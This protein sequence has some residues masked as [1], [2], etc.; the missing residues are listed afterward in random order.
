ML[1]QPVLGLVASAL[2]ILISL[3]FVALFP[4]A[5]F[6]GSVTY[7][8][9][10]IVPMEIVVG[11]TWGC[12]QP[13]FAAKR[14]QPAKGAFL[15]LLTGII[16]AIV[17][18]AYF[19]GVGGGVRPISPMLMMCT[20]VSVVVTF[21]AAIIWGGWPFT[22]VIKN[23]VAA[24][25][26]MLAACYI[27]NYVLFRLFF[28]YEFMRGAA[29][30]TASLDP[31]GLFNANL[32]LVFYLTALAVMFLM[33]HLDLWP[34]TNFPGL[35]KQ[36]VLGLV[37]TAICLALG[38][39]IFYIG[40]FVLVMD[41][42]QFM[43][44]VPIPFIFGTIIVLNMLQGSLFAKYAQPLKG[45]LSA[46]AAAVIGTALAL[47]YGALSPALSGQ[48]APG[49]PG[50]DFERWL[51]SALLGVTFPFL[52]FYAEFFE[53]WPLKKTVTASAPIGRG[54]AGGM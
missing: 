52:I 13:G 38:G 29:A 36:P 15:A 27:V 44:R 2:V 10:C 14:A 32:A 16:G 54:S 25:L 41:P 1:R 28:S 46:A 34:L 48:L 23:P 31:H 5:K 17:V 45:I 37:W 19:I 43:V 42:L 53:F 18:A 50:N 35:M 12:K 8:L 20:I 39:I 47:L 49:P 11:I 22:T 9:V 3:G 7:C 21:W 33:L 51:A 4:A 6:L 24:G 26:T 40:V 30:Y